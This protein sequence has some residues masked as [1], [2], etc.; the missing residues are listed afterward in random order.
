[1]ARRGLSFPPTAANL[2]Q[3]RS[4][5]VSFFRSVLHADPWPR[6]C[7]IAEAVA[8]HK[9]VTVRSCHHSGKC[10]DSE[11][12]IPLADGRMER[13]ADLIGRFFGIVTF[14][15]DGTQRPALAWATDNGTEPVF[16]IT[17]QSG[18]SIIRTGNHPLLAGTLPPSR[19]GKP[20]LPQPRGW[21][22]V[23][24]MVPGDLVAVP[25][26]LHCHGN[27]R[28]SDADVKLLGYLLGDGSTTKGAY[29]TQKEGAPKEE[30]CEI[31]ER[32]GGRTRRIN[33][34][35]LS[36]SGT[37]GELLQAGRNPILNRAREWGLLGKKSKEKS[38]PAWAWELPDDQLALLLNRLFACDG[39]AYARHHPKVWNGIHFV[40]SQGEVGITLASLPLIRDVEMA[41]LRLGIC[42]KVR[43]RSVSA[44]GEKRFTCWE[45]KCNRADEVMKLVPLVGIYGKEAALAEVLAV[46]QGRNQAKTDKWPRRE[47]PEGYRWD[48][49]ESIEPLGERPTVA[50]T[51]PET[52]T[53]VTTFVEHNTW[54][55][56]ALAQWFLR[57]HN[58][59]LVVTTAPTMRQVKELLW[60]EIAQHQRRAQLSGTLN[61][62]DL[63]VLPTQRAV[64]LTTNEPERFQGLHSENI[65]VIV[66]E[67]SGVEE[68]IY[69]AIEG[70]LTG[71]NAKL[72][73]IGNPNSPNGTFFQSFQS[74]L[75]QPFHIAAPDVPAHL[76]PP[77][78]L[79]E[80]QQEWG[81]DS[82][83]YQ[84]RVM[85]EFPDQGEDS[86]IAMRWVTAAQEREA[87][88]DG[89]EAVEVG[90]DIARYGSD[91]SV[92][93]ARRGRL[94][95]GTEYWR[96]ASTTASAGRVAAFA[97]R[98]DAALIKVDDI[99][100]GGGVVDQLLAE[101]HPVQGVNVGE[102]ARDK[103]GYF[104]LRSEMF[105]GLADRFRAGDIS[106]PADDTKLLA[107]LLALKKSYTPRGQM[108]L[109][110][111]DDLRKRLPKIGSP[112]RADA[113]A[114]CFLAGG[115]RWVPWSGLG[116]TR[117]F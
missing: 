16:Q 33:A 112:D 75:Y 39:W 83:A 38:F 34:I 15:K 24:D 21:Q 68:T 3:Y 96:G 1:M 79:E 4:D 25:T 7:E 69:E 8:A 66:D 88:E 82:P 80:R 85:G 52:G 63:T 94:V 60:Y 92:A 19:F 99:G 11:E 31:V 65:L 13:A 27:R 14:E 95:V 103:E 64:G 58:P 22:A 29:F 81:E 36:T 18:R 46:A 12:W 40:Q 110:S 105:Q 70:I 90:V 67:A 84:V 30:F 26:R 114:L 2:N 74:S 54:T 61:T 76:L 28:R 59:S 91:E 108:K 32:L 56:A 37:E 100:V 107:Q 50:I 73:L 35:D 106:I 5:P 57:A 44:G 77:G 72:L 45:W 9:R 43:R 10:V 71:P 78:W 113:L 20:M 89:G 104:N 101:G 51:V 93:Y 102:A 116:E 115:P 109:E 6:Q 62:M 41:M 23:Q 117:E 42:G 55:A 48:R 111:K 17:T 97:R 47:L 53:F 98:Y 86:L 87:A 49:I